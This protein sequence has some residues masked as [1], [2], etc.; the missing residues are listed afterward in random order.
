MPTR[1]RRNG[2]RVRPLRQRRRLPCPTSSL[3]NRLLGPNQHRG[4]FESWPNV[5]YVVGPKRFDVVQE[6]LVNEGG[7]QYRKGS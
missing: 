5:A 6:R 2:V 7:A 1:G 3:F 4:P